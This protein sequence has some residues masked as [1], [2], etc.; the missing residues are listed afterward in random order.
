[1][2]DRSA[3]PSFMGCFRRTNNA[4]RLHQNLENGP[5]QFLRTVKQNFPPVIP[6]YLTTPA[7]SNILPPVTT[8]GQEL[9]FGELAWEDFEKLCLRLARAESDIEHCQLY[10]T[11]GQDQFGIDIYAR[12]R[13]A[14]GYVVYQCKRV[15]NFGPADI[16]DAVKKF[17]S[18]EWAQ[19]AST[20]VLCTS[21]SLVPRT[22]ANELEKQT[23]E[24]KD[25]GVSLIP[26]D[27]DQLSLML[28]DYPKIVHD[29][30]GKP[31]VERF[32]GQ[33]AVSA[34][35]NRLDALQVTEFRQKLGRFYT[36]VFNINDPG[37]ETGSST[38]IRLLPVDR[39]FIL[40]DVE[41]RQSVPV[42]LASADVPAAQDTA[43]QFQRIS[44]ISFEKPFSNLTS[45]SR[46]TSTTIVQRSSVDRWLANAE[47]SIVLGA[48]GSGKSTLLRFLI[49]DL[50]KEE[51]QLGILAEKWGNYLP[52]WVPFPAWTEKIRHQPECSLAD[53]LMT[54]LRGWCE[55]R[56]W[57]LLA[58]ALED[59]RLLLVVDGLD[60]WS[61][62]ASAKQAV[63]KLQVFIAQR[64][65]PAIVASR[66]HG[67][68]K[69]GWQKT[70]WQTA[71]L[72][73]LTSDQQKEFAKVWFTHRALVLNQPATQAPLI[74]DQEAES[75]ISELAEN[76]NLRELATIPLLLGI[77]IY[78]R[79]RNSRLPQNRFEAYE[80]MVEQLISEHPSNR[81]RAAQITDRSNELNTVEIRDILGML[82]FELQSNETSGVI[83]KD[84]AQNL[85]K[86]YLEDAEY[87]L[88]LEHSRAV[89]LS[90][91]FLEIGQNTLG[92]LVE[93]TS[94]DLGFFHR[95]F[96]EHLAA[97]WI[98]RMPSSKQLELVKDACANPQWREVI[99]AL[100]Y[101]T[102]RL[103]DVKALVEAIIFCRSSTP[104]A[105]RYPI[106]QLLAEIAFG[107]FNCPT[108]LARQLAREIFEEIELGSWMSHR[109]SLLRHALSG[110]RTTTLRDIVRA[111]VRGWLPCYRS[112]MRLLD[113]LSAWE[114]SS[115]LKDCFFR[116]LHDEELSNR[117]AAAAGIVRVGS[118]NESIGERLARLAASSVD[119][120]PRVA[121]IE[122]L[123]KGWPAHP[124]L[125]KILD[126][127]RLSNSPELRLIGV[128]GRIW[129]Q[130]HTEDDLD[131]LLR[132]SRTVS[133]YRSED[134]VSGLISGWPASL[135]VKLACFD[136]LEHKV[137]GDGLM[138]PG[139]AEEVLVRGFPRDDEV[140]DA[141]IE[142][143]AREGG[144]FLISF[145]RS[146]SFLVSN[147]KGHPKLSKVID[148]RFV[149]GQA[150][151]NYR[152]SWRLAE[153][154]A[155]DT[156]KSYLVNELR[157]GPIQWPAKI[158]LET[159][160]MT[161]PAVA[162]ELIA[163]A[164][165]P[166]N[167]ASMIANLI[168]RIVGDKSLAQK[169]LLQL[170]QDPLANDVRSIL[171]GLKL[172]GATEQDSEV[173]SII[174]RQIETRGEPFREEIIGHLI[175]NYCS[176]S[177]V[178]KIAIEELRNRRHTVEVIA[179]VYPN[180]E[181]MAADIFDMAA[182]LPASLRLSVV[183]DPSIVTADSA[184]ALEVLSKWD[185]DSDEEVKTEAS[186][187]YYALK[188]STEVGMEAELTKLRTT[189]SALGFDYE[190]RRQAAF[191]G[192]VGLRRI[193]VIKECEAEGSGL[194]GSGLHPNLSLV[195]CIL[196]NWNLLKEQLG[197]NFLQELFGFESDRLQLWSGFCPMLSE[198]E[199]PRAELL[200]L[201][202]MHS[203][204]KSTVEILQFL[205]KLRSHR[206]LF[207]EYLLEAVYPSETR[208]PGLRAII[209]A[210]MLGEHFAGDAEVYAKL[211]AKIYE[212][213]RPWFFIAKGAIMIA[214][215]EGWPNSDLVDRVL[216]EV[217]S[218]GPSVQLTIGVWTLLCAKGSTEGVARS[219]EH[220]LHNYTD[221]NSAWDP[222]WARPIIRRLRADPDLFQQLES[223]LKTSPTQTEKVTIAK[224]LAAAKGASA[225]LKC[226]ATD[227]IEWQ[228]NGGSSPEIGADL[229]VGEFRPVAHALL[230]ILSTE[231]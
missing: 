202:S 74:A 196:Q 108:L 231:P 178:R 114:L 82:A 222:H 163:I 144:S 171:K 90:R 227:E 189:L 146:S 9:P 229:L 131:E 96:Q 11:R 30:F 13:N 136:A 34:L 139:F 48:P 113:A 64:A 119:R 184:F 26:W 116:N 142:R 102:H 67:F 143:A 100:C 58:Q 188:R 35:R 63:D 68:A 65:L 204:R 225:D 86:H 36:H 52:V 167:E 49:I 180:D 19:K 83:D 7:S 217:R 214:L 147:F 42:S 137:P 130:I 140:A 165:G 79:F 32:C 2:S 111:K 29:F 192:L 104:Q 203:E 124:G 5:K 122:A 46:K 158:L 207:L 211:G 84:R 129:I 60:E 205:S 39:R 194:L 95:T 159:W 92:V 51:P 128:L 150:A 154:S 91:G 23:R 157:S 24:L 179:S 213:P 148:E 89:T 93:R 10:G 1:M 127:A 164:D 132:L 166:S 50:L 134:I 59:E 230:E 80:R 199:S 201:L 88:G 4:W 73:G 138:D 212:N 21:E 153:V 208:D 54:Y 22:R 56:L 224:M 198:Y 78:F 176:D 112:R 12:L 20:L 193:D 149:A 25:K 75:F 115:K 172:L 28:K 69:L 97:Y 27:A 16:K 126:Q 8:S 66:P 15:E 187:R 87:G 221:P 177:R 41:L 173:L 77:F 160:G 14:K 220:I 71:H 135:K 206:W 38:D 55:E 53:L 133:L 141:L 226:W 155:S 117:R 182:P 169:R 152:E 18:G 216:N 43:E 168:P 151:Y 101:M 40:P 223:R 72:A 190:E 145:F 156:A 170:L 110:L 57:P 109:A 200:D 162:A 99:L 228:Y 31:W 219:F 209:A 103:E 94:I 17:L 174:L 81:Q 215:C 185:A 181:G 197:E 62:E 70:G 76:A 61:D 105:N 120:E 47:N 123:F 6:T 121:S 106:Q 37:I 191:A 175:G 45:H 118:A 44:P 85:V 195:K 98:S 3:I 183:S 33:E 107:N 210:E 186:I 218:A 161:D 125:T